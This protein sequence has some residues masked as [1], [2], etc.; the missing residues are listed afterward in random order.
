M[1]LILVYVLVL[2]PFYI[3]LCSFG[4]GVYQLHL[5]QLQ[6]L[7]FIVFSESPRQL[8]NHEI[9]IS[10]LMVFITGLGRFPPMGLHEVL[11]EFDVEP[12]DGDLPTAHTC[13]CTLVL[14]I[15]TDLA[16]KEIFLHKMDTAILYAGGM[17]SKSANIRIVETK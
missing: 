1:Y 2:L 5:F 14:P 3:T 9:T 15:Y 17:H 12:N 6:H 16:V 10:S 11:V 8:D 7:L 4:L 13:S